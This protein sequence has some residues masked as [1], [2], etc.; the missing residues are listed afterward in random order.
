MTQQ[1]SNQASD[2]TD[3]IQQQYEREEQMRELGIERFRKQLEQGERNRDLSRSKAGKAMDKFHLQEVI[4]TINADLKHT[5]GRSTQQT[6]EVRETYRRVSKTPDVDTDT[7]KQKLTDKGTPRTF[8]PWNT[9][10]IAII[11]L[12]GMIDVCR[13][14]IIDMDDPNNRG[15]RGGARPTSTTLAI[16]LGARIEQ[17]LILNQLRHYFP[18]R[19]NR[20][21]YVTK[22]LKRNIAERASYAYKHHN[23]KRALRESAEWFESQGLGVLAE[24]FRWKPWNATERLQIGNKLMKLVINGLCL[25]DGV[26]YFDYVTVGAGE[27]QK[28]FL[29]LSEAGEMFFDQLHAKAEE[30][31]IYHA[32]MT[33]SAARSTALQ[34]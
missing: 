33:V 3:L 24:R 2:Q 32:A 15:K 17:Q 26:K 5:S 22:L 29:G 23:T 31:Q 7:G 21:G 11:V 20:A 30:T 34:A 13:M 18:D 16:Q 28:I 14:P 12:R 9:D 6:D 1:N 25:K 8:N 19:A 10:Q 27:H 4:D